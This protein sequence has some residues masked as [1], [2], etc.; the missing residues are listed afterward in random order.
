MLC[1]AVIPGILAL[2]RVWGDMVAMADNMQIG[3]PFSVTV[4]KFIIMWFH[5]KDLEPVINMIVKD[6][7]RTK[8]VQE[9]DTMIKQ[10]RIARIM[11]M[12]GCT[13]MTL[14]CIILIIPPCFGYTTRYLTNL[15]DPGRPMLVQTYYLRD[16]TETPLYEIV[17][18]AQAISILM[19]AISYTGI[20]TFLCLLVFHICAQM[21]ILKERFLSL[22]NFKDF[23]I[24]LSFNIKDHLRLIRL[25]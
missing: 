10:A 11:V 17:I 22:N 23:D 16:I 20:D 7:L 13:M 9:R 6:W 8:T 3:L 5:K 2:L 1:A 12:F 4:L 14:A 19:A 24:G 15:T 25:Y 18:S 21:E